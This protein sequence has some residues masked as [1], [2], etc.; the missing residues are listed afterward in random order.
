MLSANSFIHKGLGDFWASNGTDKSGIQPHFAKILKLELAHLSS[1]R[2]LS[3]IQGGLGV[4]K[5]AKLLSGF[6]DR[7]SMEVNGPWR[8]TFTCSDASTG[9]VTMIDLENYHVPG[10]AKR[11]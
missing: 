5:K 7:Y 11:H 1:A 4:L 6:T 8:L 3:D 9:V 10:G 2:S